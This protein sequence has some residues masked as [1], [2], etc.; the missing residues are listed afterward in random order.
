MDFDNFFSA[1]NIAIVGVSRDA[2]KVGHIIFRN[3]VDANYEGKVYPVNHNAEEIL[4]RKVY[5]S[6][7][8]IPGKLDLVIIA[9]PAD[10]VFPIL[11]ECYKKKVKHVI[12]VTAGFKEVGNVIGE[13]KLET[14]LKKYGI[15]VIGPNCLGTFDAYSKLD[16]LFL[17][18]YRLQRPKP[19]GI[20]FV[21]QSGA[22]GSSI[23]D[24]AT[25]RGYGFSKFISYGNAIN[26]DEADLIEYLGKDK[27]T[28]VIC[29]YVEGVVDGKKFIRV[30][31]EVGKKKP[32]IAIKGG[33]TEE[34]SKAAMSHTGSLAG[35]A[36]IYSAIFR[37]C[38]VIEVNSLEEMFDSAK[39]LEKVPKP[40]NGRRVLVITNGGGYGILSTDA[41]IKNGLKLA[42]L[43]KEG[44]QAL[45][46]ALPRVAAHNPIDLLGDANTESYRI[47]L[48]IGAKD[49]NVDAMLVI[50]LYQTPLVGTDVVDVIIETNDMNAK[51]LIVVSA[52]GEFTE[53]LSKD[54]ES[55]NVP[56]YSF[57]DNAVLALKHLFEFYEK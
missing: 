21:C 57:P 32:I 12:M 45:S 41:L 29:L 18:R 25:D 6:L 33:K 24:L 34:G 42:E 15:K 51:P 8:A 23:L 9:I 20:S 7:T 52:G 40:K 3:F 35:S 53:V 38:G 55:N 43:S 50:V 27:N 4:G 22:V 17:P 30:A 48:E 5:K 11:D 44:T 56:T 14:T 19:G 31:K 39:I 37:Q 16:S 10:F 36:E 1:K 13:K 54:V 47:A 2:K 46:K 26:V 28:K 49:K